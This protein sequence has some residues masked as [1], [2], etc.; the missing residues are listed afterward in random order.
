M[1][2]GLVMGT[3][4]TPTI[5]WI[6]IMMVETAVALMSTHNS[7]LNVCVLVV[8]CQLSKRGLEYYIDKF[9]AKNQATPKKLFFV[10]EQTH[11][12]VVKK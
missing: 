2:T 5:F 1:T 7:A 6:V 12:K 10:L 11:Q 8:G 9:L 3:V 4:M